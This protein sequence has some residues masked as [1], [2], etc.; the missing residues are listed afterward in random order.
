MPRRHG[1]RTEVGGDR[2]PGARG[3]TLFHPPPGREMERENR[4]RAPPDEAP[5]PSGKRGRGWEPRWRTNGTRRADGTAAEPRRLPRSSGRKNGGARRRETGRDLTMPAGESRVPPAAAA[6]RPS[7]QKSPRRSTR[8]SRGAAES[9]PT[10]LR[11]HQVPHERAFD[12]TG[13]RA[14]PFPATPRLPGRM[15]LRTGPRSRRAAGDPPAMPRPGEGATATDPDGG[16]TGTRLSGAD[17]GSRGAAAPAEARRRAGNRGPGE[18]GGGER[19]GADLAH[20]TPGAP[21]HR[22]LSPGAAATPAAAGAI[23]WKGPARVQS[24]RCRRPPPPGPPGDPREARWFLPTPPPALHQRRARTRTRGREEEGGRGERTAPARGFGP[25]ARE[26]AAART[27]RTQ[28]IYLLTQPDSGKT[29]ARRAGGRYWPHTVH[30]LGLDQKDL[31]PPRAAP[32]SGSSVRHISRAALCGGDSVAVPEERACRGAR[33]CVCARGLPPGTEAETREEKRGP[34]PREGGDRGDDG[35]EGG[36]HVPETRYERRTGR[37]RGEGEGGGRRSPAPSLPRPPHAHG[38]PG[39]DIGACDDG[40]N[41][42]APPLSLSAGLAPPAAPQEELASGAKGHRSV[43]RAGAGAGTPGVRK[44]EEKQQRRRAGDAGSEPRRSPLRGARP[45][46]EPGQTSRARAARRRSETERAAGR[47]PVGRGTGSRE[48][49]S[50]SRESPGTDTLLP[51]E[52]GR[53]RPIPNDHMLTPESGA[54]RPSRPPPLATLLS[55][56]LRAPGSGGVDEGGGRGCGSRGDRG[57]SL[58]SDTR[59]QTHE[60]LFFATWIPVDRHA[61][62]RPRAG[63]VPRPTPRCLDLMKS[64]PPGTA[65]GTEEARGTGR[66]G[67]SADEGGSRAG[68]EEQ[69]GTKRTQGKGGGLAS[70]GGARRHHRSTTTTDN[71]AGTRLN[72]Y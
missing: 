8:C 32:G 9:C 16:R 59:P 36:E 18:A 54:T 2:G 14:A 64:S 7:I 31:G 68:T 24:R 52:G 45:R 71:D 70:E 37:Q 34:S 65:R 15:A 43:P 27:A 72:L 10:R 19:E 6:T 50:T 42:Q 62:A 11:G 41:P 55:L 49:T 17:R 39:K 57:S 63:R 23:Q 26:G 47:I 4:A 30:G 58:A 35:T 38:P 25:R 22:P 33:V 56:A 48:G 21:P 13:E 29:R 60:S 3:E 61:G 51:R 46:R 66:E 67:E 28:P 53:P 20:G 5:E 1:A 12:V 40:C 69:G 44:A